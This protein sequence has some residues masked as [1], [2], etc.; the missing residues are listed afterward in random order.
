MKMGKANV[1]IFIATQPYAYLSC[2]SFKELGSTGACEHIGGIDLKRDDLPE[3]HNADCPHFPREF[4][5]RKKNQR[6]MNFC[7]AYGTLCYK[8]RPQI[9]PLNN[10]RYE[11]SIASDKLRKEQL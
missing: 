6:I 4:F 3:N 7:Q 8:N 1:V 9:M 2:S 11:A 10:D 5:E